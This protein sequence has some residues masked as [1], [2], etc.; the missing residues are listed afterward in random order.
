MRT[1]EYWRDEICNKVC[2]PSRNDFLVELIKKIQ[3]D[4]IKSTAYTRNKAD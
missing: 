1:P 2:L 3:E 4:A